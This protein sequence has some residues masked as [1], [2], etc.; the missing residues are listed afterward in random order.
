MSI[1]FTQY[2]MPDGR[3]QVVTVDRPPEI[4]QLARRLILLGLRFEMEMLS[5]YRTVSLTLCDPTGDEGEPKDVDIELC[6]NGPGIPDAID[7]LITRSAGR[8]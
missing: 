4:E 5:D 7:R 8:V 2:L 3:T 1:P 6:K